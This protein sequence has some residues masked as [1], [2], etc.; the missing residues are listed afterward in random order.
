VAV[1]SDT[2][3]VIADAIPVNDGTFM[4]GK[5]VVKTARLS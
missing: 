2:R 3:F 4:A 1:T 5:A